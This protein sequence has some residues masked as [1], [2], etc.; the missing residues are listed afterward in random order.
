MINKNRKGWIRIIE[1]I[2]A[3]LL[4][5]G[6]V[7]IAIRQN[8]GEK[9]D[10]SVIVYRAESGILTGIQLNETLREEIL[11]IPI[12]SF[13]IEWNQSNSFD[14]FAPNTKAVINQGAPSY[15][16]C[17]GKICAADNTCLLENP[18]DKTVYSESVMISANLQTYSPRLLK[19]FCWEVG[20]VLVGLGALLIQLL[21]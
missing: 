5:A 10:I 7:L 17:V 13:P 12:A 15:L 11:N 14:S 21:Q 9:Q 6:V 3:I 1:S 4:I 2:L 16:K 20:G 18:P 8:Q 19:L